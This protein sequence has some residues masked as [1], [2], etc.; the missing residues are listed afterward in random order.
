[1]FLVNKLSQLFSVRTSITNN[2]IF[3]V[4]LMTLIF[5]LGTILVYQARASLTLLIV[6]FFLAVAL[7]R[8][9]NFLAG[10]MPRD[11][12]G[13]ATGTAYLIVLAILGVLLYVVV[14]PLIEQS[15]Q[16]VQNIPDYIDQME[17]SSSKAAE[18]ARRYHIPEALEKVHTEQSQHLTEVG[19]PIF[20]TAKRIISSLAATITVLVLTFFMVVEGPAWID[21][22]WAL[23]PDKKRKHR[24]QLAEQ[25]YKVITGYV[26]GQLFIATLGAVNAYV[27]AR[28]V[29]IPY[30]LPVAGI[31]WFLGLI[32]LIGATLGGVLMVVL[33]LFHSVPA[34]IIL[35]VYL[36]L[37]QQLE[38]SFLQ[39]LVQSRAVN[40][41][42]LTILAAALIGANLAGLLGALIAIPIA[43]C[44]RILVNDYFEHRNIEFDLTP[45]EEY[46][47]AK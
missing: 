1:M 30:A 17:T 27:A 15:R 11:S 25:M 43:A 28:I 12:R 2:T 38:N 19:G 5:F 3:R 26:N 37:Y 23:Q 46:K 31:V 36:I 32:P 41:S 44:I 39:P 4:L 9:V 24:K 34:A 13:L 42:P 22:F 14:P 16:F 7:S 10:R 6:A 29:G 8:P 35:A 18:L 20:S 33:A 47:S 40:I 45:K 21:R